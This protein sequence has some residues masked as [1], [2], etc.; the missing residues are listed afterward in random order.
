MSRAYGFTQSAQRED[1]E[2]A[3]ET[4]R[5]ECL[6]V[7]SAASAASLCALCVK[8]QIRAGTQLLPADR[9]RHGDEIRVGGAL[10]DLVALLLL[11]RRTVARLRD[12]RHA[13]DAAQL[14]RRRSRLGRRDLNRDRRLAAV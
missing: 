13:L 6:P 4:G 11:A 1:A 14:V 5:R 3:E 12:V 8:R 2:A 7:F 10:G 9:D